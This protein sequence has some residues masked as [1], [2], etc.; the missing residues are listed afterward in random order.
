MQL[1]HIVDQREVFPGD[2]PY[3]SGLTRALRHHFERLAFR[4]ALLVKPGD[5]AVDVGCND[6]TLLEAVRRKANVRVLGVEPTGQAEKC[7]AKGITTERAFFTAKLGAAL[8]EQ[9]GPAAV[10]TACNV[11]ESRARPARLPGGRDG[12]AG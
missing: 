1:S 2:H 4:V 5:L 10:V 9:H 6:G 12:P 11:F 3:Q 7:R 8:R